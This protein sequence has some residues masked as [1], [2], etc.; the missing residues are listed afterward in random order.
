[1]KT[2]TDPDS[3]IEHFRTDHLSANLGRRSARGGVVTVAAQSVKLAL[4]LGSTAVL[5]RILTPADFGVF[6]MVAVFTGFIGRFRDLGLTAATVQRLEIDHGQVSTLFWVNVAAGTALMVLSAAVS[7]LVVWFYGEEALAGIM[8][9]V[10]VTFLFAGFGAQHIALLR[11]QMRF[12]ALACVEIGAM[13]FGIAAAIAVAL[14]GGRYWALVALA[15]GQAFASTVL[16]SLISGWRPGRWRMSAEVHDM[17][18]FG[19]ALTAANMVNF[20]SRNFDNLVIGRYWGAVDLG[21]YARAY[22]LLLAPVQ[23]INGPIAAVAVPALARLQDRKAEYCRY[24]LKIVQVIAY[25][26]MPA[27]VLLGVLAEEVVLILLGPQW[28]EVAAIFRI[29]A[30]FVVVQNVSVTTGWVL[31]SLGRASRLFKWQA[32]HAVIF[33][34][35]CLIGVRW[36]AMGV[37]LVTTIQG[38]ISILPAMWVAYH[39]SPISVRDVMLAIFKPLL[40]AVCLFVVTWSVHSMAQSHALV[41]R[42]GEVLGSAILLAV[43]VLL[44]AA[45]VRRDLLGIVAAI[46]SVKT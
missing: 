35:A 36:G 45:P 20:I 6:A 4:Q 38:L 33:V 23:Q 46:R 7:P 26:S 32:A 43:V 15:T 16:S 18:R 24:Y 28:H 14:G 2:P 19:G 11:R 12:T 40:L 17:L 31:Q 21:I 27:A 5:A 13:S 34:I 29:F 30:V 25:I 22:A 9:A 8:L 37:A 3:S 1:M 39:G 41:V 10:S 44:L 42:I